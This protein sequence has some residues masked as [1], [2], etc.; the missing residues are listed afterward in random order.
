[1]C[2]ILILYCTLR[3]MFVSL[4]QIGTF[5]FITEMLSSTLWP[6]MIAPLKLV[7]FQELKVEIFSV[8]E[9]R[10]RSIKSAQKINF[11]CFVLITF[12]S[13][14]NTAK[15]VTVKKEFSLLL[16]FSF[17]LECIIL[18]NISP[19]FMTE[20]TNDYT[21]EE[22]GLVAI[23]SQ[24]SRYIGNIRFIVSCNAVLKSNCQIFPIL[25]ILGICLIKR[26]FEIFYE[27]QSV[28][29]NWKMRRDKKV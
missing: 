20:W 19:C 2:R 1:M 6:L 27:W 26:R 14:L 28:K 18:S 23:S 16:S 21:S 15:I 11:G 29:P 25:H 12:Y 5:C 4:C 24:S 17:L 7:Q 13:L 10:G 8:M 9:N 3:E 22:I